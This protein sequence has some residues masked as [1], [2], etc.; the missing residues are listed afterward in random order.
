MK[1]RFLIAVLFTL[2]L[3]G[4]AMAQTQEENSTLAK[5]QAENWKRNSLKQSN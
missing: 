1:K 2:F 4:F 5:L 3:G